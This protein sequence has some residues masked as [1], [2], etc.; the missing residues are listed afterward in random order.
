M[1]LALVGRG[2]MG[3]EVERLARAD[4]HKIQ[5]TIDLPENADGAALTSEALAGV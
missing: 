3:S 1:N 4:G 2:R 5:F